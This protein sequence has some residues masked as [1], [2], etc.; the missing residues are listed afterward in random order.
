MKSKVII[1]FFTF[2]S[3]MCFAQKGQFTGQIKDDKGNFISFGKIT[4][5]PS[6]KTLYTDES[7]YFKSQKLKYGYYS[8]KIQAENHK[9]LESNYEL[10]TSLYDLGEIIIKKS[11]T[12]DLNEV[13]VTGRKNNSFFIRRMKAIEG[14]ILTQGKKTEVISLES[15]DANKAT[16]SSRQIFARIPGLNIWESDGSGI[17]IGLGGRGLNPS[18]NVNFNTRQNGY[19]ISADALGYP[20]SYYTPPSEAIEEIQMIRGAASLQFGPQFGGLIN[21]QLKKGV[22]DKKAEIIARHTVGSFGL[23]NSYLSISGTINSWNYITYGN[24][25]FGDDWR[26]NS[27]FKSIQ[28]H[29]SLSKKITRKT[30]LEIEFTKMY[31]LAQQPGGLTDHLF[32]YNPDTSLRERNWFQVNWNMAALNI[33]YSPSSNAILSSK[34]F[35]LIASRESLGYLDQINR[36]D[37]IYTDQT[38][39]GRNLISGIFQNI[40]NETRYIQKYR[41][42]NQPSAFVSG[43]RVYKG[44][45]ENRQGAAN[46]EYGPDFYF[47]GL[48]GNA[49]NT[50]INTDYQFPSFN[51]ALFGEHIFNLT[52]KLGITPGIRYEYI[53]TNANGSYRYTNF[54]L[55]GNI[56]FDTLFNSDRTSKREFVIGGLGVTYKARKDIELYSNFS[57]NYRSIH[58]TEMQI[59]NPNFKIDP[60]LQ[61][62]MGFNF[63]LGIR[64]QIGNKLFFDASIYSM[65]YNNRIG[66]TLEVDPI[67]YYT[68]QYRTNISAS[69]TFGLEY[70]IEVDWWKVFVS[71]TA[72]LRL[73]TFANFSYNNA[74]YIKSKEPA[75]QNKQVELV[76]PVVLKAGLTIGNQRFSISY[77]YSFTQ[78]HFSDATNSLSQA[79][80][81]TGIIPSYAIM[82]LSGKAVFGRFKLEAGIN[83]LANASYFT[84]RAVAYPGPGIIPGT[85][86][87]IY[88]TLQVKI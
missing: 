57:Q 8:I 29:V 40:G 87:N 12:I 10:K 67:L 22:K 26:P 19:D 66:T 35:G 14:D 16:N 1:V 45:S 71:D 72:D 74:R 76:P 13:A 31:Y 49:T 4:F 53:S 28:G 59:Q 41:A 3:A 2:L 20:E 43:I 80:S 33:Q 81:V 64:G 17:Q 52:K 50:N 69:R 73:S 79:N 30:S 62:E 86:R 63:D 25:K 82:D 21:Y 54:D 6:D 78:E 24:Y 60:E 61:D 9:I 84:R 38:K 44:Y 32:N 56:V 48:D 88:L 11:L 58:F 75:F 85:I 23:N 42:F 18:R 51:L 5:S 7:G 34:T 15:I 77:Q 68:Y 27:S 47:V 83:N 70:I 55:A 65:Y 39:A 36:I 46:R 37:P